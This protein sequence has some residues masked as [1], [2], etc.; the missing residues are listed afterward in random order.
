MGGISKKTELLLSPGRCPQG[1][2][3]EGARVTFEGKYPAKGNRP[4]SL[5][6]LS[7]MPGE[8]LR[9]AHIHQNG[10]QKVICARGSSRAGV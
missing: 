2:N 5:R 1:I 3:G 10:K 8:V 7:L 4:Q 9:A 6:K